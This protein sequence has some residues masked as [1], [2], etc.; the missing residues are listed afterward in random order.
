[1]DLVLSPRIV[2]LSGPSTGQ[3]LP[4]E[5]TG[6]RLSDECVV[7][8]HHGRAV[9]Y[10]GSDG[11]AGSPRPKVL[12][13]HNSCLTTGGCDFRLEHFEFDS[14]HVTALFPGIEPRDPFDPDFRKTEEMKFHLIK[15]LCGRMKRN[16]QVAIILKTRPRGMLGFGSYYPGLFIVEQDIVDAVQEGFLPGMLYRD[17][18]F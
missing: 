5:E 8:L 4:V 6:V 7:R 13:D 15:D 3:V 1:M 17:R 12:L 9:A 11:D 10:F 14:A 2:V 16:L 18:V